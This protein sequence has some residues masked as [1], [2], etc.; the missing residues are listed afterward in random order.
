ML[1]SLLIT[2]LTISY[3]L[4]GRVRVGLCVYGCGSFSPEGLAVAPQVHIHNLVVWC[5]LLAHD[6]DMCMV[7]A[8]CSA[9]MLSAATLLSESNQLGSD[10]FQVP[11]CCVLMLHVCTLQSPDPIWQLQAAGIA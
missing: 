9:T 5:V 6:S 4:R 2:T 8:D 1:A 3:Q 11:C 10:V 7:V